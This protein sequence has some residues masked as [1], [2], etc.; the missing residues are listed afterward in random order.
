M[1]NKSFI[2]VLY[3]DLV[4]GETQ[5]KERED[6]FSYLGGVGIATKLLEEEAEP[7]LDALDPQQPAIFA[8][9]AFSSVFPVATKGVAM[10]KSPLTGDLGESYAGGRFFPSYVSGR[11]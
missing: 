2:R 3:V 7:T 11:L 8:M 5:I 1:I 6:L 9:G 4:K 10:F